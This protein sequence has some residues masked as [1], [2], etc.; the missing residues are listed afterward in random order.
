MNFEEDLQENFR[1][2]RTPNTANLNYNTF[3]EPKDINMWA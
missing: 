3:R 2:P 1:I